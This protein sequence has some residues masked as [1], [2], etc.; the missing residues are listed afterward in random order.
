MEVITILFYFSEKTYKQRLVDDKTLVVMSQRHRF[1][2][3]SRFYKG[4]SKTF[5]ID[6]IYEHVV[7]DVDPQNGQLYRYIS[8]IFTFRKKSNEQ[9]EAKET[10]ETKS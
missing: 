3:E 9:K 4:A 8:R 1:K 10:E 7:K 6:K 5:D 2:R